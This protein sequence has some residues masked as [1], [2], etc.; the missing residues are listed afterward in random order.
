MT[1]RNGQT[2]MG[3]TTSDLC[4]LNTGTVIV[5]APFGRDAALVCS[6]F[7][8]AQIPCEASTNIVDLTAR[9][10]EDTCAV[11]MV[12]EALTSSGVAELIQ[13]L[14]QQDSWSDLPIVLLLAQSPVIAFGPLIAELRAATNVTLLTRPVPG[15][16]LVSAMQVALRARRRQHQIRDLIARENAA[17]LQAEN[18]NRLK[19][20]FLAT[21]SHELRTPLGAILLWTRL[22]SSGRLDP[23]R[24]PEALGSI[25]HCAESQSRLIEDLLDMS[26]MVSGKL[27]L[28]VIETELAGVAYDAVNVVQP[29]AQAK[30]ILVEASIDPTAG[31]VRADTNRV[32][33]V[34]WNLLG[35]AIK[36]TPHNGRVYLKL[37]RKADRVEIQVT[38]TGQ[39]IAPEFLPHVFDRFRQGDAAV[40]R[41]HGGLGLGLAITKQ[42]VELHGG[43]VSVHSDGLNRGATF[44]VGLPLVSRLSAEEE[45][46]QSTPSARSLAGVVR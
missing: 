20:E 3:T 18:A 13:K 2:E 34:I 28:H 12:E 5:L 25:Q 38:D 27:H 33:Q 14:G 21:V 36:F 31:R 19:D 10:H 29:M 45:Q 23:A 7:A 32:Q 44:T 39:G 9:L 30:S 46:L 6:T 35:N 4:V 8:S 40:T 17:R 24:V 42:L 26:R 15:V 22:M 16:V 1:N 41:H 37:Q 43:T 11:L